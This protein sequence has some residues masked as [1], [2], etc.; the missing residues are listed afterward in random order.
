MHFDIAISVGSNCQSRFNISRVLFSRHSDDKKLFSLQDPFVKSIDFG[1]FFFDWSVTPINSSKQILSQNF[2]GVL[3]LKNLKIS[4]LNDGSQTI[5]DTASGCSYPHTFPKTQVG[6]CTTE[7]LEKA[8][9]KVRDKYDYVIN[10][11]KEALSS[12]KKILCV[13]TGNHADHDVIE[14][15]DIIEQL[16]SNFSLLYTPW[17]NRQGFNEIDNTNYD[18]RIIKR[19]IK[20]EPYPGDFNSWEKAFHEISFGPKKT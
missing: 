13:L 15:C 2:E 4:N 19:P 14:L 3:E 5:I 8:Y 16:T 11:T 9:P 1:S 17:E 6:E 18:S 7:I 12:D 10:K 20:H